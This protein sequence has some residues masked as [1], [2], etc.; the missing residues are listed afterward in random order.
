MV[1][2]LVEGA[3]SSSLDSRNGLWGPYWVNESI[4]VII[5][6]SSLID[7]RLA[8]T[9][10]K[11]A[12]WADSL[13]SEGG[14]MQVACWFDKET[15]GNTGTL[16]H[17]AWLDWDNDIVRYNTV[18]VTTG[19]K[20]TERTIDDT[21]TMVFGSHDNRIAITQ[22]LSGRIMIAFVT[23]SEKECYQS[24]ETTAPFFAAAPTS[25]DSPY[26][27]V[28]VSYYND[29]CLMFPAAT[30]DDDDACAL[31]WDRS[32][33]Q[34]SLKVYDDT[35][36]PGSQ[37]TEA[38]IA[39]SMYDDEDH[40]NMDGSVRHSDGVICYSAHS[41]DDATT[42]D[43]ITGQITIDDPDAAL[44]TITP[45][46][47]IYTSPP[48]DKQERAQVCVHI[49]QQNDDV[50]VAYLK[51]GTWGSLTAVVHHKSTAAQDMGTWGGEQSYSQLIDDVRLVSAGRTCGS[52]GGRYQP[53]FYN[54]DTTAIYINEELDIELAV[55]ALEGKA[56]LSGVGSLSAAASLI[57]TAKASL[58][59]VGTLAAKGTIGVL[60]EAQASLSG[61][62]ALSAKAV[63]TYVSSASMSGVGTLAAVAG[64]TLSGAATLAGVGTL[65]ARAELTGVHEG[66]ASL[67]GA[68]TMTVAV[69]V[70]RGAAA[71]LSGVGTMT[72]RAVATLVGKASLSGEGTLDVIGETGEILYTLWGFER[73]IDPDDEPAGT[74]FQFEATLKVA[75]PPGGTAR[76]RL[77]NVTLAE[78]VADSPLSTSNPTKTRLRS[79]A[80]TLPSG[81]HLYRA[82]YGGAAG[83]TYTI[84]AAD[85][86]KESN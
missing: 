51:G 5:Y 1:D 49:D 22:A 19:T 71:S 67:S 27:N 4:G 21:V 14:I 16:V 47:N 34:L 55:G 41:N 75:D 57:T 9:D 65:A 31:F 62:G 85:L 84:Y 17:I 37:W 42:D 46:A 58:S 23:G 76:V 38:V 83:G 48:N 24:Q 28:G 64:T 59:G 15:P 61:T 74:V 10:D 44:C 29:W 2:T 45:K 60:H 56:S 40:I 7:L 30:D 82:E 50:R 72:A 66:K 33:N 26:E 20:G 35:A 11:G 79:S 12:T 70:I 81:N 73:E 54:D 3:V 18:D 8:W 63:A 6:V 86:R 68:G 36:A 39:S 32:S 77:F 53:A 43:L 25:V 78:E 52:G 69:E 80:L 13:I